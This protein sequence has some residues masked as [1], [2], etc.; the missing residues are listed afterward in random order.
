MVCLNAFPISGKKWL[1]CLG[2]LYV[3]YRPV[4][5]GCLFWKNRSPYRLIMNK[6]N[7]N[8]FFHLHTVS[9][10]S[11]S[12]LLFVIFFAGAFALFKDE[13][14]VWEQG[15]PKTVV[16][17]KDIDYDSAIQV[18]EQKG[19]HLNGRDL[20]F[21]MPDVRNEMLLVLSPSKNKDATEEDKKSAYFN[22]N[23][24]TYQISEYYKF[25]SFGELIYRFHFLTPIP[26]GIYIAGFVALFFLFAIVTGVIVH[27]DKIISNFYV[28]RPK[29]KLKT[30]WT[31][32]HTALGMI[33]LPFQFTFALTS[34]FLCLSILV[35]IPANF[36]YN[37]NQAKLLE[38]VRPM[39]KSYPMTDTLVASKDFNPL[40][41]DALTRWDTFEPVQV[42]IKNFGD[43]S[44][45][46]Q[47]DGTLAPSQKLLSVGRVV[48]D[49]PTGRVSSVASPT[50]ANY[51][52][53]VEYAVRKLHFGDFGGYWLKSAYFIMAIITCF[54]I[55]S[56]VL[57]WLEA[58]NKKNIPEKRK[59]FSQRVGHIYLSLCLTL[60]PATTISFI[61]SKLIPREL[62]SIRKAILHVSFFGG[63]LLMAF[64]F[65]I[66]KN[67]FKT[68]QYTLLIAAIGGLAIPLVNGFSSGNWFWLTFTHHQTG[69]F[70]IDAFWL[71]AATLTFFAYFK[72]KHSRA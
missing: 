11:I 20:R 3:S 31:D 44:M 28:F 30:I 43:K 10:I 22:I 14:A 59:K 55:L 23:T 19:Y 21:V 52:E 57:I 58:R 65:G 33:G 42:Y 35:L 70:V 64:I 12:V 56:G 60:Y 32:A 54:V 25:Y 13:I 27:W 17:I 9:G 67:N 66:M 72:L 16:P 4:W 5:H 15:S 47:V 40:M 26:Y 49:V 29:A 2:H 45:K 53:N 68:H 7:Y 50:E 71:I 8:I 51:L 18:I 39:M 46:F 36:L 63:W 62:D 1:D 38:D 61:V 37:N 34:C 48:Y 6:R 24:Q 41:K 69:I